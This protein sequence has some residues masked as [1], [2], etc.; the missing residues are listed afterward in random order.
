M[1]STGYS[2]TGVTLYLTKNYNVTFCMNGKIRKLF[3][4]TK[5]THKLLHLY[6]LLCFVST[7]TMFDRLLVENRLSSLSKQTT[8]LIVIL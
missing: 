6:L 1:T 2:T 5:R 7:K 8:T 4:K 3:Q